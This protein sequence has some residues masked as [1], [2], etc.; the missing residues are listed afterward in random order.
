MEQFTP[1]F[2][3]TQAYHHQSCW[4]VGWIWNNTV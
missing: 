1:D 3:I 4:K 2:R